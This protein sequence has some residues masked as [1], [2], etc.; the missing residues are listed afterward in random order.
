MCLVGRQALL[1]QSLAVMKENTTVVL[2]SCLSFVVS[3]SALPHFYSS[4]SPVNHVHIHFYF[5]PWLCLHYFVTSSTA[6]YATEWPNMCWCA[7]W[8]YLLT[9]SSSAVSS[10]KR[11]VSAMTCC[12]SMIELCSVNCLRLSF[13]VVDNSVFQGWLVDMVN[14][15][16]TLGGFQLLLSR[17]QRNLSVSLIASLIRLVIKHAVYWQFV[18]IS[19][20]CVIRLLQHLVCCP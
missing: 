2:C 20:F 13:S 17:F 3:A 10:T 15:F 19:I 14:K 5:W 12:V 9:H 4:F 1:N 16:G 7:V 6:S 18:Y 11:H 8:N